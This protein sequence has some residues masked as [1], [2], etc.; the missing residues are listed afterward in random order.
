MALISDFLDKA[1]YESALRYFT[2]ANQDVFLLH[3]L[4]QEEMEPALR[5]T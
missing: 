2:A 5:A 3:V 4:A 1:G